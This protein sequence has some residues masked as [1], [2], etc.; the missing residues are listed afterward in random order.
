[1]DKRS[2]RHIIKIEKQLVFS[3]F[4]EVYNVKLWKAFFIC[5]ISHNLRFYKYKLIYF[6]RHYKFYEHSNK[7]LSLIYFR[8]YMKYS[9]KLNAEINCDDLGLGFHFTHSC[10]VISRHAKIGKNLHLFGNNAISETSKGAPIIG[11]NVTLGIGAI[12]LGPITIADNCYI[13]AGAI[14]TKSITKVGT[15]VIGINQILE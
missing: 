2:L 4:C 9:L 13:G 14:V 1:M 12:I 8:F 7:L 6:F 15:K 3:D 10:I 11:D 5:K